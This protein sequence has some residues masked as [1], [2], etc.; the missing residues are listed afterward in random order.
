MI[1]KH[2]WDAAL[3][4][5]IAAERERLGGSPPPEDVV[6][7]TRGELPQPQAARVRALLVL[8]PELTPLLDEVAP[9]APRSFARTIAIA[10]SVVIA[11]LGFELA[12]TMHEQRQ[13]Y[14]YAS[15]HVLED[16]HQRGAVPPRVYELPADEERYL[17]ELELPDDTSDPDYRIE[18]I[19][20][21]QSKIIW[22]VAHVQPPLA[23]SVPRELLRGKTYRINVRGQTRVESFWIRIRHAR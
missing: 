12:R 18:I 17:I 4:G 1:T 14:V 16:P 21:Q 3:D 19:D 11:F 23:I 6:A 7:F 5:W 2:D 8:D 22:S 20:T 15:R 9:R 13:P 10:A